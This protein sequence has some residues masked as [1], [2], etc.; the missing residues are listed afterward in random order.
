[1]CIFGKGVS[2]V[3]NLF[4]TGIDHGIGEGG[5]GVVGEHVPAELVEKQLERDR[6]ALAQGHTV[7]INAGKTGLVMIPRCE[8]PESGGDPIVT[9]LVVDVLDRTDGVHPDQA[10]RVFL[11]QRSLAE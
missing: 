1:M 7:Y 5:G 4:G 2:K 10:L 9:C 11:Q 8:T 6:E 3:E